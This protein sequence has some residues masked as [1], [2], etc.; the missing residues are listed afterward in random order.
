MTF[1]RRVDENT[2]AITEAFRRLGCL[3]HCT[4]GD[5]DL[6][7]SKFNVTALVEVKD[8][9][10]SPSRKRLTARSQSLVDAGWPISRVESLD[11]VLALC[12]K[13]RQQA[14]SRDGA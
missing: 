6:T 4:N 1:A 12:D 3:V 13:L 8:G 11:D 14:M 7:V 2:K 5:W 9:K 10:K